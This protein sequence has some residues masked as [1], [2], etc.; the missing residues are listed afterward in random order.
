MEKKELLVVMDMQYT[1][2]R[3]LH[4]LR[5]YEEENKRHMLTYEGHETGRLYFAM[6]DFMA[7]AKYTSD[8][9]ADLCVCLD[10]KTNRKEDSSEY[11]AGRDKLENVDIVALQ[12]MEKVIVN[13]GI[14]TLKCE[15]YEADDCI[16]S[17]VKNK[18]DEYNKIVIFTPDSD[19][20]ALIDDK[21]AVFRYK[22]VYSMYGNKGKHA[23]F[24]SAHYYVDRNSYEEYLSKENDGRV[25]YNSIMLLKC[26]VG[27]KSDKVKGIKGF[28]I[29]AFEK[30]INQLEKNNIDLRQLGDADF[31]DDI[32]QRSAQLLGVEKLGEARAALRLVRPRTCDELETTVKE[33]SATIPDLDK[34][35]DELANFGIMS[36]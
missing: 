16:A 17:V 27:D 9:Q 4:R 28:G 29:R 1:M 21:V 13:S 32:I 24:M 10:T 7:I 2:R 11:K 12:N 18:Y 5:K 14:T 23:D 35:R 25:P 15:G 6:K 3:H 8:K 20:C 30:Y 33:K 36:L 34:I 26:T 31:V 22:S 19:L